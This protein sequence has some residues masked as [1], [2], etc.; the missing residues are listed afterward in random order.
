MSKTECT[1]LRGLAIIAIVIHNFCH[2]IPNAVSENEFEFDIQNT[3]NFWAKV[4]T[5]DCL[6]QIASYWGYLG[7]PIFVFLSG[8]GL[9]QKYDRMKHVKWLSY[10]KHNFFKLFVPLTSGT[11]IVCIILYNTV[12][13]IYNP[14]YIYILQ[15]L[16]LLNLSANPQLIIPGPYWYFGMT[17][18]LYFLYRLLIHKH[19]ESIILII[20]IAATFLMFPL[21]KH[22]DILRWCRYNAIGWLIPFSI[23]VILS[24]HSWFISILK[25]WPW[26]GLIALLIMLGI[27]SLHYLLWLLTPIVAVF[28][29]IFIVLLLSQKVIIHLAS[30][31]SLSYTLFVIHPIV[32]LYV[33]PMVPKHG[34]WFCLILYLLIT[35]FCSIIVKKSKHFLQRRF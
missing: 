18:Q 31:G 3:W 33:F 9:S 8:Y 10:I 7:V 14:I 20:A 25:K 27:S 28:L 4:F 2:H 6:L 24:R 12:G 32:K 15:C 19:S 21:E 30:I 22:P 1:A 13:E 35:L 23:G 34:I 29:A 5:S 17:M 16:M 26:T 11:I